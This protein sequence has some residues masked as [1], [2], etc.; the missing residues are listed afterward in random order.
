MRALE[1]GVEPELVRAR[2]EE[3]KAEKAA[4]QASLPRLGLAPERQD[5]A[6]VLDQVPDLSELLRGADNATKRALFD[7]FDLRVIYNKASDRLSISATLTEAVAKMLSS[8]LEP[9][10]LS[11]ESLRGWDSNPQPIG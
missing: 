6:T 4:A 9:L 2:V 3:L 5:P 11:K 10:R 7:A 1:A 8:G